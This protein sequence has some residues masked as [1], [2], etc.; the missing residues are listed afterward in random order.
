[1]QEAKVAHKFSFKNLCG[2]LLTVVFACLC[3][4]I[5]APLNYNVKAA[6]VTHNI[7]TVAQLEAFRDNV[8][9]GNTYAGD[10]VKL[11]ANLNLSGIANWVSIGY[12]TAITFKGIFDGGGYTIS[13]LKIA[14]TTRNQV[15]L[16]GNASGEIR[17]LN[18]TNASITSTHAYVGI[19][20]G[21]FDVG[22]TGI[23]NCTVTN[24]TVSA[25]TVAD[26]GGLAGL[27]F[28][29]VE[30]CHVSNVTVNGGSAVGGV[31]GRIGNSTNGGTTVVNCSA[32]NVTVKTNTANYAGGIVGI[33]YQGRIRNCHAVDGTI[34]SF[35][36]GAGGIL[37][38]GHLTT[39]GGDGLTHISDCTVSATNPTTNPFTVKANTNE[40]GGMVGYLFGTI[41]N[42]WAKATVTSIGNSAGGVVG[43]LRGQA[44]NCYAESDVSGVN[45]VGG[46]AGQLIAKTTERY[47]GII[48]S[49]TA[50]SQVSGSTYVGGLVGYVNGNTYSYCE[51]RNSGSTSAVYGFSNVGGLVGRVAFNTSRVDN[52]TTSGTLYANAAAS[53]YFGGVVG[54]VLDAKEIVNCS[55]TVDIHHNSYL[56]MSAVGGIAGY[57]R[58]GRIASCHYQGSV[59][60]LGVVEGTTRVTEGGYRI[61]GLV[62]VTTSGITNDSEQTR[63]LIEDC[64]A[65]ITV[66]GLD[67]TGYEIGGLVGNFTALSG[68]ASGA[69]PSI[70][71]R[72]FA[73]L[74]MTYRT[75]ANS[76][77]GGLIGYAQN[78]VI[79]ECGAEY[80]GNV[81]GAALVGCVWAS[82]IKNSYSRVNST[83]IR[84]D[85]MPTA[86]VYIRQSDIT[87]CYAVLEAINISSN[88]GAYSY[89]L[90]ARDDILTTNLK[91]NFVFSN[92]SV[93]GV[94]RNAGLVNSATQEALLDMTLLDGD[95]MGNNYWNDRTGSM[96]EI[97]SLNYAAGLSPGDQAAISQYLDDA[98][99]PLAQGTAQT[100]FKDESFFTNDANW[101][102][103]HPWDFVSI[104]AIVP[105][106]NDGYPV[107]RNLLIRPN[108]S[109]AGIGANIG[110]MQLNGSTIASL[111]QYVMFGD[112]LT[113]TASA[114]AGRTWSGWYLGTE[115]AITTSTTLTLT[116]VDSYPKV[117]RAF[118][119][120]NSGGTNVNISANAAPI[121]AGG[122][123]NVNTN[124]SCEIIIYEVLTGEVVFSRQ[125]G[126]TT[127]TASAWNQ[128][129]ALD[130][131]QE[132]VIYVHMPTYVL[133]TIMV[134][135][136][137]MQGILNY[138]K[139]VPRASLTI[140]VG[141]NASTGNEN[142]YDLGWLHNT[143][144]I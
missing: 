18:L 33:A 96:V 71:R 104:W 66:N 130:I 49:C 129:I 108:V 69:Y 8:N 90:T 40:S 2:A 74:N 84:Y 115:G 12:T 77:L 7:T 142:N 94:S 31:I 23:F 15:G 34:E 45:Y 116:F 86:F 60:S 21:D 1:M 93:R 29:I 70:I 10:T 85:N 110:T 138:C 99:V 75:N 135:S 14:S 118:A 89:N 6:G 22:G 76:T 81:H 143:E 27:A 133:P 132:Y 105:G 144:V 91:N 17:N 119:R 103:D 9:S 117:F 140:T 56:T 36:L 126:S 16:F 137:A 38:V 106:L 63:V 59:T 4:A 122:S 120:L 113:V 127:A 35:A 98:F 97:A 128:T 121:R 136:L 5:P 3:V 92:A 101:H 24:S 102:Q 28:G 123:G 25:P 100:S 32:T 43:I 80:T 141:H 82:V 50:N 20:V 52:C 139:F 47:N 88:G 62:G 107:L 87:N 112:V 53:A 68:S 67:Y 44:F 134:G 72:S 57:I 58:W 125:Y 64:F 131:L 55:S 26:V 48:D 79:S 39:A 41:T 78:V 19:I 111:P 114:V 95:K 51:V 65:D 37:A 11:G 42:S 13:N 109:L 83:A 46:F 54:Y 30:N 61:G 73:R 124:V